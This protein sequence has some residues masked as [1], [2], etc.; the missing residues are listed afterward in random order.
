MKQSSDDDGRMVWISWVRKGPPVLLR[1]CGNHGTLGPVSPPS[2]VVA[3]KPRLDLST[4]EAQRTMH[5]RTAAP[6]LIQR[7]L[8][9][10]RAVEFTTR[11]I[12]NPHLIHVSYETKQ[13]V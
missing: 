6:D 1:G 3:Q 2:L 5:C 9:M 12:P 8:A 4:H 10:A 11:S 7:L 13:G